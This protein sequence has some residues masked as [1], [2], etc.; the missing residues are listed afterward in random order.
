MKSKISFRELSK[1]VTAEVTVEGEGDEA[2]KE[3]QRLYTL[4]SE[5]S[6]AQTMRKQ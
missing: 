1:S 3:A 5:F 6:I 2:L 4:A